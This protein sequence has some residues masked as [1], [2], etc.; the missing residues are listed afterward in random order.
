M[1]IFGIVLATLGIIVFITQKKVKNMP[2]VADHEKIVTLNDKNFQHQIKDKVILVDF[3]AGWCAP[4]KLMAPVLN[5]VASELDGKSH[6]G[7]VNIELYQS[8]A[9]KYRIRSIPTFVLFKNGMEV[10]RIVGVK[11]KEYLLQQIKNA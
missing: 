4:C 9:Q 10:Q 2:M 1:I 6:V 8:L 11:S 5:E 3:W 7:K